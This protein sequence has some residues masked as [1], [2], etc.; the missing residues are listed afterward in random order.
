MAR[1]TLE[2]LQKRYN[3]TVKNGRG[4]GGPGGPGRGPRRGPGLNF[5]GIRT[6]TGIPA[7]VFLC[8][9]PDS[10]KALKRLDF[11]RKRVY[12]IPAI[13]AAECSRRAAGD[14]ILG[15]QPVDRRGT[16]LP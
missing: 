5:I 15:V 11:S 8:P 13:N 3:S 6:R 9:L 7:R 4:M 10:K 12:S 2:E 1:R 14:P 16:F